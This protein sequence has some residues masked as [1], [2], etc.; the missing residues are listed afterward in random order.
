MNFY[1]TIT[2]I[3][4]FCATMTNS[5]RKFDITLAKEMQECKEDACTRYRCDKKT[6]KCCAPLAVALFI[7][8]TLVE[9]T[10]KWW[11]N[12]LEQVKEI[13]VTPIDF[14]NQIDAEVNSFIS[15]DLMCLVYVEGEPSKNDI[16]WFAWEI[17]NHIPFGLYLHNSYQ[18]QFSNEWFSGVVET[19]PLLK[20]L[21]P[22]VQSQMKSFRNGCGKGKRLGDFNEA[23]NCFNLLGLFPPFKFSFVCAPLNNK[24]EDLKD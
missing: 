10:C 17:R 6:G 23:L 8:T 13:S 12:V 24:Y 18:H 16:H 14:I 22:E 21:R 5:V 4:I 2:M 20:N 9:Y 1:P 11:Y 3:L 19:D 15:S 7:H